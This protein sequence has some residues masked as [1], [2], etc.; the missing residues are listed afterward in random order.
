MPRQLADRFGTPAGAAEHDREALRAL[1]VG[2]A[3]VRRPTAGDGP[4]RRAGPGTPRRGR[5]ERGVP[6]SGIAMP[7]APSTSASS[8]ASRRDRAPPSGS[9]HRPARGVEAVVRR[10]AG[11]ARG[12]RATMARRTSAGA[13]RGH[14][15]DVELRLR[16]RAAHGGRRPREQRA[17]GLGR[18]RAPR[19][20][21]SG[22]L[23]LRRIL[24][25]SCASRSSQPMRSSPRSRRCTTGMP[26]DHA[27][28]VA[29]VLG[30]EIERALDAQQPGVE[31]PLGRRAEPVDHRSRPWI[32]LVSIWYRERRTRCSA[33]V[34]M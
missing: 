2:R 28:E 31:Q 11:T 5:L 30:L 32:A 20:Q 13:H 33:S 25:R 12:R 21:H 24:A 23:V 4:H 9:C 7:A 16:R 29:A 3:R 18:A 34:A 27:V 15:V 26:G 8:S 6:S 19:E 1:R 10:P 22:R 14:P 17:A